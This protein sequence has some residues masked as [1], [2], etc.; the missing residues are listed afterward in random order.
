VAAHPFAQY[1][2]RLPIRSI[3]EIAAVYSGACTSNRLLCGTEHTNQII[4]TANDTPSGFESSEAPSYKHFLYSSGS[5]A[6]P[7]PVQLRRNIDTS[8]WKIPAAN[9]LLKNISFNKFVHMPAALHH[10]PH[11][12]SHTSDIHIT[13]HTS[14]CPL[15]EYH[16]HL[17]LGQRCVEGIFVLG[18]HRHV[19][20]WHGAL[21]EVDE[22]GRGR[23]MAIVISII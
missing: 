20:T 9:Q 5:D 15:L 6:P 19:W 4:D 3:V 18:R 10:T 12:T 1:V 8:G 16:W 22:V 14:H 21:A 17:T 11:F 7:P 2:S 23:A 13:P